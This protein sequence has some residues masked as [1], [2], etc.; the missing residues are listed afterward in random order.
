MAFSGLLN[1]IPYA[2]GALLAVAQRAND[3]ALGRLTFHPT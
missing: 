1:V 3:A 2:E